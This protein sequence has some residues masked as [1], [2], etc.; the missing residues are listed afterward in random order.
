[1]RYWTA[2]SDVEPL[3]REVMNTDWPLTLTQIRDGLRA[4]Y[5]ECYEF[6][7]RWEGGYSNDPDDPGGCTNKG[8]T[9]HTLREWRN[10]PAVTCAHVRAL[11]DTEAGL[12]YATNYW[13]PV[14]GSYTPI[15][16]N[17]MHWDWGVN[18]GP[19]RATR[20]VQNIVG[21]AADGIMGPKTLEA[22]EKRV[23]LN[24]IDALIGEMYEVRQA[25]YR[26]LP[27]FWKFGKGWSRRNSDCMNVALQLVSKGPL[28]LEDVE[29]EPPKDD[30][31]EG[32]R[33]QLGDI[34]AWVD[35]YPRKL[36]V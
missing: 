31:I 32:L 2:K 18:S 29:P 26:G 14:W 9:I 13:A 11:S 17:L 7:Q 4:R 23:A 22:I 33:L 21:T 20:Y 27:T 19:S 34:D 12:I 5:R 30:I 28:E 25:F 1:M 35:S 36:R 16:F 15:G 10:D 24:G 8:I 3:L 6:T